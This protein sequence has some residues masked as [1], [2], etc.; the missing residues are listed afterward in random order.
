MLE[1]NSESFQAH[2]LYGELSFINGDM[3]LAK[4]HL[5]TALMI[6][7]QAVYIDRR[8]KEIEAK[9]KRRVTPELN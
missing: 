8:L 2:Y 7:P 6:N 1:E 9:V 5:E 3:D 4:E